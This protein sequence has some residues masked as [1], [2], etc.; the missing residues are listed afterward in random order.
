MQESKHAV[1]KVVTLVKEAEN[2]QMNPLLS[3]Y[4]RLIA[5]HRKV[6]TYLRE[7]HTVVENLTY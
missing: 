3:K 4:Y 1:S 7:G 2:Y 5:A 6:K